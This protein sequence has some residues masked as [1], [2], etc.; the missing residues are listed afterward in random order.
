MLP[1]STQTLE[2]D[3]NF[4]ALG[5]RVAKKIKTRAAEFTQ[6]YTYLGMENKILLARSGNGNVQLQVDGQG[7]DDPIAM[8]RDMNK[9]S[10]LK[11]Y[12]KLTPKSA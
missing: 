7:I 2:V 6:S 11:S 12:S 5:R 1:N 9:N 3:Y 4:D 10:L 8:V